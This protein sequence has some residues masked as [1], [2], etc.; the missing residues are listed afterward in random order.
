MNST[1]TQIGGTHYTKLAIQPVEYIH[2]NRLGFIEG[3]V[4][5]Y[6]TRWRDKGGLEDLHKARHFID[7]LIE[8]EQS[9]TPKPKHSRI[10]VIGQNGNDGDHYAETDSFYS[11]EWSGAL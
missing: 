7:L 5:K 6:V 4:V 2:K 10:D 11:T 8:M 1:K 9:E 3:C